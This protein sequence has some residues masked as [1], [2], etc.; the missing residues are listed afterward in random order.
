[1]LLTLTIAFESKSKKKNVIK[2]INN[3]LTYVIFFFLHVKH[4]IIGKTNE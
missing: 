2:V 3:M 1:M 4:C